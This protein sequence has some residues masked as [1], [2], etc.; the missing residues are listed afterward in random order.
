ML[1]ISLKHLF[2]NNSRG[3]KALLALTFAV[4]FSINL[5]CGKRK[6]P[7]PPIEQV[8]QR[9]TIEG[10]QRGN[11]VRLSWNLPARNAPDS[12]I[13]N[14]SRVDVYRLTEPLESTLTLSEEEFLS[15]STLIASLPIADGD[16][17]LKKFN[18]SDTL[19]FTGQ[20]ARLR[21]AVRF[22]NSAGQ[23]ASFSNFLLVEPLNKVAQAPGNLSV[24]NSESAV[25][26]E[27][28]TPQ[29]NVDGTTPVNLIGYNVYRS[30]SADATAKLINQTPVSRNAY[31]DKTFEFETTYFYFVR[32]VSLGSDGNPV[33]SLESNIEKVFAVDTFAP[34][35]PTGI[36]VAA[37]PNNLSVF[38]AANPERDVAGYR[39]YRSQDRT[40]PM[41]QW[42][43]LT[44]ELLTT[45]TFQDKKIE[46]GKT[47]YYYL[48]AVD[49]SGNQSQPSEIFYE[50]AP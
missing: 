13:S 22:V 4:L 29:T 2:L 43:N 20:S 23:K 14:I 45:N 19:E 8:E 11:Q 49:K 25:Q 37:A 41:S 48:I 24:K 34:S 47:Y 21:Y 33:E 35:A 12:S 50:T 1:N 46:S 36:T 40:A 6:P 32:S 7:L 16:F 10:F 15:R 27:W 31:S 39:L 18:Y 28:T 30:T 44:A 17:G 42:E 38:F 5:N 26:L 3:I 9:A